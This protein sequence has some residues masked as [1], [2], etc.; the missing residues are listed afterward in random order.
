MPKGIY[1]HTEEHKRKIG[2]AQ[3]GKRHWNWKGGKAKSSQ[4]YWLILIPEHPRAIQ[5]GYVKQSILV[6]EKKI[7]RYLE[8]GEVAH[9]I[10]GIRDDDR[11][12]NLYLM[13]W[14]KHQSYHSL[15]YW[16]YKKWKLNL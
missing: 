10:N 1:K 5:D 13:T 2:E 3:T 4:D 8:K 9:H 12:E 16:T 6:L 11:P 7:G 15:L 14:S